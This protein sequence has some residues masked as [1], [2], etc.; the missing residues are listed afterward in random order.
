[1]FRLPAVDH[2]VCLFAGAGAAAAPAFDDSNYSRA[3]DTDI[4]RLI[5]QMRRYYDT[6]NDPHAKVASTR[7]TTITITGT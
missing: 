6:K 5:Q 3:V 4:V 7:S 1:M 2:K